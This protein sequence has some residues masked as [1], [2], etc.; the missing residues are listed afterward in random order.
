ML[1]CERNL[2]D[3]IQVWDE[4]RD[5]SPGYVKDMGTMVRRDRNHP[6]VVI[7]SVCNEGECFVAAQGNQSAK[8]FVAEAKKWDTTRSVT[9]SMP[10]TPTP[11]DYSCY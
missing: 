11:T 8:I 9:C 2:Y 10:L 5:F 3:A 4:N 1:T 7:W 6:S